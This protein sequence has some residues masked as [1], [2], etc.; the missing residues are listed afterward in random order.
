MRAAMYVKIPKVTTLVSETPNDHVSYGQK[1]SFHFICKGTTDLFIKPPVLQNLSR[2]KIYDDKIDHL[3][4]AAVIF[5]M[6][7]GYASRIH[8]QMLKSIFI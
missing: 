3:Q 4:D 7:E 2:R 8:S 6:H 1:K 5:L